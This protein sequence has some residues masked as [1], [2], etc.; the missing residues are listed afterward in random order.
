MRCNKQQV[1]PVHPPMVYRQSRVKRLERVSLRLNL[2]LVISF[3]LL[4]F[5]VSAGY[6]ATYK[7]MRGELVKV[8]YHFLRLVARANDHE[9]FL[10]R[11]IKSS[12]SSTYRPETDY[13]GYIFTEMPKGDVRIYEGLASQYL[14]KVSVVLPEHTDRLGPRVINRQLGLARGLANVYSDFWIG[15]SFTAP[16]MFLF[17]L[18]RHFDIAIPW[19]ETQPQQVGATQPDLLL[20]LSR[21]KAAIRRDPPKNS[22]LIVRWSPAEP[23]MMNGRQ[24]LLAYV[25]DQ[26]ADEYRVAG[27]APREVVAA[28]L[29]ELSELNDF[30]ER[31]DRQFYERPD[32]ESI[33]LLAPD[34]RLLVGAADSDI[35]DYQNGLHLSASGLLIKRSAGTQGTWQALYRISYKSLLEDGFW[36]LLSLLGLLLTCVFGG[37]GVIE[38]YRRRVVEPAGS[39]FRQLLVTHDFN[40]SILQT[41]P[42]A[43]CVVRGPTLQPVTH[44][45]LYGAWLG[46]ATD[47][48]LLMQHWEMFDQGWP[49]SGEGCLEVGPRSLYVRFAPTDYQGEDVLLCTFTDITSH[50]E[51]A[52]S[53]IMARDAADAAN[54][55]KSNFVATV[56]HEIRTPLYGALGTLEL[57]AMTDLSE[58]QRAYLRTIDSSSTVLLQLISDVLDVSKIEAGQMVPESV[59]FNPRELLEETL[60][61]FSAM[62]ASKGLALY[63]CI[64]QPLPVEV[65]GDSL[66]IRQIVGNLISNAIKFTAHG[67]VAV[68]LNQ[69]QCATGRARLQWQVADSGPGIPQ[70]VQAR[71]FERFYQRDNR[72]PNIRGTGLGLPICASLGQMLGGHL[73][74][75]SEE[76]QGST[77]SF[78]LDL[79]LAESEE[80]D[81]V[82]LRLQGKRVHLRTP[83]ADLSAS[84]GAWLQQHGARVSTQPEALGDMPDVMLEVMPEALAGLDWAGTK[85]FAQ[86]DFNLQPQVI[87]KDILV[88]QHSLPAI[89]QALNMAL[90][91]EVCE[92]DTTPGV[93]SRQPLGL[94]VLLAEDSPV[95]QLL[96]KEQLETIGC[97]VDV[98]S[99]GIEGLHLL[100]QQAYDLILTDVNMP[101]MDGYAFAQ[102]VR[103]RNL[104]TPII[105]VTANALREEGEHCI[106][107]GMNNWLTKPI[108]IQGLY[109]CLKAAIEI[110]LQHVVADAVQAT[111]LPQDD[112]LRVPE[113][114][115][116]LFQLT[117]GQ[118]LEALKAALAGGDKVQLMDQLHRIRGALAV[119][120]A[121]SLI[122]VCASLEASVGGHGARLEEGQLQRFIER[123]ERLISQL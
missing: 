34:G 59:R 93:A 25:L 71:L 37:W 104:D 36:P 112:P 101:L 63:A 123:V 1:S 41:V 100:D 2:G 78:A 95:N 38:W 51:A 13:R 52:A 61:G 39:D 54:E 46:E 69:V 8:N 62:A 81:P 33:D 106:R 94:S 30:G 68:R 58:R 11:A 110:P 57:L 16:Q 111:G 18:D 72:Q 19:I 53:L 84:L 49:I 26:T 113:R 83:F 5:F 66:R 64:D 73:S 118:D 31:I 98:A 99:N 20:V 65:L 24:A 15:S 4:V 85:V 76:G 35:R 90:T 88:N 121:K 45:S 42:L 122:L 74:F 17:D 56:S 70:E 117:I 14:T 79:E 12:G 27:R 97:L 43:L 29:L 21:V 60:R 116:E 22:D 48:R 77:F 92:P 109:L 40:H 55:Q 87:G 102:S 119:G 44:N 32:F 9:T 96:M 67:R 80:A 28:T 115:L 47:L 23:F 105:G 3:L 6:W 103:E 82:D 120:K 10:L 89:L 7:V 75:S 108:D 107:V 86:H 114:M 50:R 91:G